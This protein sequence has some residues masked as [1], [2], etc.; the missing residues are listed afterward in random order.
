[1]PIRI[2]SPDGVKEVAS[3]C[4]TAGL[5]AL[6]TEADSLHSYFHKVC[7]VQVSADGQH[8]V[9][10][11]LQLDNQDLTPLWEI[12]A[13]P[14]V[15][16]LMHGADYDVR[17]LDR[18]FGAR[19]GGLRDTQIMAQLL[20]EKRTGLGVLL[21]QELGVKLNKRLQRANWGQRPLSDEL[22]RYASADTA[23]LKNLCSR[24][25]ERLQHLGRWQW[26]KEDCARLEKV[27]YSAPE[28]DPLAFERIKGARTLK[29]LAR[30]RC[31]SLHCWREKIARQQ[32]LPPFKIVGN[33]HLLLLAESPPA[34]RKQLARRS[35]I[36]SRLV[37]M[38]G[39]QILE[40]LQHPETAPE[41]VRRRSSPPHISGESR[42][43]VQLLLA[44]RDQVAAAMGL[45]PG[46]I[47]PKALV[48]DLAA[49][50]E[51]TSLADLE[52]RGLTGWRLAL[53]GER[54]LAQR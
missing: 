8:F 50:T 11:P 5:I 24:F 16:V 2:D 23:Y 48:L 4:H 17:V 43:R 6:D 37:R 45:E 30:N 20:G 25:R 54:F 27:R 9:I 21:T 35:G 19:I 51:P 22:L 12:V 29:D 53:L 31:Y 34:D 32:D 33:Q 52:G 28:P 10:D 3:A 39:Q 14:E 49:Q 7:L 1:M 38:W 41:R 18:D 15:P 46:L 47:C 13:E 36:S 26:V 42:K 40:I 44:I